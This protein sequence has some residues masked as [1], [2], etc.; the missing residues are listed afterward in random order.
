M[1]A[2]VLLLLDEGDVGAEIEGSQRC[3][4]GRGRPSLRMR[5]CVRPRRPVR[6]RAV[7]H[8]RIR[9]RDVRRGAIH[10]RSRSERPVDVA[11]G[12]P[13]GR[14]LSGRSAARQSRPG[15]VPASN[16]RRTRPVTGR[17][18]PDREGERYQERASVPTS[19][20]GSVVTPPEPRGST[21]TT[22]RPTLLPTRKIPRNSPGWR[23]TPHI[24][25]LAGGVRAGSRVSVRPPIQPFRGQPSLAVPNRRSVGDG[26][27]ARW[28]AGL[29]QLTARS[30]RRRSPRT[31]FRY[32][33]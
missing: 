9:Q 7:D 24:V 27:P 1:T 30:C 12:R 8:G 25:R 10:E 26:G 2:G 18:A 13:P 16:R 28:G 29:Q 20:H 4:V 11:R 19:K 22:I 6:P 31:S 33:L 17:S 14:G 5:G 32:F 3:S 15:I 23:P 21:I